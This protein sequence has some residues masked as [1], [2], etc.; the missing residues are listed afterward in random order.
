MKK[1]VLAISI[2]AVILLEIFFEAPSSNDVKFSIEHKSNSTIFK[3]SNSK[4]IKSVEFKTAENFFVTPEEYLSEAKGIRHCKILPKTEDELNVWLI[5]ANENGEPYEYIEDVL[6]RFEDCLQRDFNNHNFVEPLMKAIE[7]GYDDAVAMLWTISEK[8]YFD[9]Q[10]LLN[11]NR[12]E[13]IM[14]RDKFNKLKYQ[15]SESI[16]VAGGEQA[17]LRLV[18]GYQHYDPDSGNPNHLKVV[19]YADFGLKITQNDSFY[20]K[21][22]FIK[23]RTLKNINALERQ[24]AH[25]LTNRLLD[26]FGENQINH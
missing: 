20:L 23:Q 6:S 14:Q 5:N 24:K 26:R 10:H 21:L 4:E 11:L 22:D 7:L 25:G 8:E 2:L 1:V 13:T 17:I 3:H 12:E 15:L 19:A 9:S 16:A 18:Q